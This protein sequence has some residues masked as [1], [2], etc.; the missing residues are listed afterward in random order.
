M[1]VSL[2]RFCFL[3]VPLV[4]SQLS[5]SAALMLSSGPLTI[6]NTNSTH[7]LTMGW[8][9]SPDTNTMGYLVGYGYA[10]GECTN[11]V[12][13]GNAVTATFE[14]LEPG[15]TYYFHVIAYDAA[16]H[17]S[18]PSTEIAFTLPEPPPSPAPP[19]TLQ[20]NLLS[21]GTVLISGTDSQLRTHEIQYVDSLGNANWQ[22]L[23]SVTAAA[24]TGHF[25]I[26]DTD[27]APQRFYRS[28][29]Q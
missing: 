2:F 1:S 22:A 11:Q 17:T 6:G 24:D 14:G 28:V 23:G 13:V 8:E 19:P 7:Y 29:T 26:T 21:D 18:A 16:N 3:A 5:A 9:P 12:D 15:V 25:E 4:L 20:I 27:A 10:S